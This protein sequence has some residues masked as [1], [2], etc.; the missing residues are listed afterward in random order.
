MI[1][2]QGAE[3]KLYEEAVRTVAGVA[4]ARVRG[5]EDDTLALHLGFHAMA[6]ELDITRSAA[7]SILYAASSAAIHGLVNLVADVQETPPEEVTERMVYAAVEQ[8]ATGAL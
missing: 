7:W 6:V 1:A 2:Y 5:D 8:V 4:A 3:L